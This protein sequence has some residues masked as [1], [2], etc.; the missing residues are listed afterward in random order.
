MQLIKDNSMN[1]KPMLAVGLRRQ[2][3]IKT[4]GRLIDDPLLGSQ[5]L[6]PLI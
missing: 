1:I 5:D 6:H 4:V 2:H 3:L